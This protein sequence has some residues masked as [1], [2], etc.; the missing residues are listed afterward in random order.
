MNAGLD[1]P[2]NGVALVGKRDLCPYGREDIFPK[3]VGTHERCED[4]RE[5]TAGLVEAPEHEQGTE[6]AAREPDIGGDLEEDEQWWS[7][8]RASDLTVAARRASDGGTSLVDDALSTAGVDSPYRREQPS[9]PE[10]LVEGNDT[11][12]YCPFEADWY[13]RNRGSPVTFADGDQNVVTVDSFLPAAVE[14]GTCPHRAMGVLLEHAE[15]IV[16]NYNH[17]FDPKSRQLVAGLLDDR[18]FVVVDESHRLEGR[19]R[20]L[21]SDTL[22]RQTLTQARNDCHTLLSQ[23]QQSRQHK[24]EVKNH[25]SKHEVTLEAIESARDFYDD[26]LEWLDERIERYLDREFEG[27]ANAPREVLPDETIE[28]PL[29]EP[30]TPEPD[31]LTRWAEQEGYDGSL[32]RQLSSIGAAVETVID[33]MGVSRT[34]VCAAAG[35][36]M[37]AWWERDHAGFLREIELEPTHT[38]PAYTSSPWERV[39][40]PQLVCFD[41]MPKEQLQTVFEELGGGILMSATLEPLSVFRKVSGLERLRTR[42]DEGRPVVERTYDL[43]FPEANRASWIVDATPFTAKNRGTAT[44]DNANATRDEYKHVLRILARSRG[45]V[46]IAM[47]NYREAAWAGAYLEDAVE[48]PVYVDSSSSNRETERLKQAFFDASDAVLV[49][50]TRGTLTEG[51]DYDGAK[52][53]TC[54]VV[55]IPLPNIGSPRIRAVRRAYGDEF[56][57]ENAFE[58]ALTVPAVRRAR[59]ALGRVIR[60]ADE[61]GVRVLVG[62]RYTPD[63]PYGSVYEYLPPGERDEFVQMT[64]DFLGS[65]FDRFWDGHRDG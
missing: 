14:H 35:A 46:M 63:A 44:L 49:T 1:R 22:G 55:G 5:N 62:Q 43:P 23:A 9:A 8:G 47:P 31:E 3:D 61:V 6:A 56:G 36:I 39:Y 17:L 32:W 65:Q 45:N 2:L 18:T 26:V 16:G 60:G 25:L 19:V 12:L 52:L 54:A 38:E 64:A 10:E 33:A 57:E 40:T 28:I 21:L 24:Q 53:H 48:Q 20:D 51:V 29:R 30:E 34:C 7:P 27:W 15:V 50:S 4:L 37:T 59:Q 11:P 41:C 13:A 58:Y 42:S